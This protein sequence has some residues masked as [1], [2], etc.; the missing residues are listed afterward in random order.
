ME[1]SERVDFRLV[2]LL[3]L[4]RSFELSSR[5]RLLDLLRT[6]S[7]SEGAL[8]GEK[9]A[10]MIKGRRRNRESEKVKKKNKR[11][12]AR[13]RSSGNGVCVLLDFVSLKLSC[14][15][16]KDK[17]RFSDSERERNNT[18]PLQKNIP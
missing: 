10:M 1:D 8:K 17:D 18:M 3:R 4:R 16:G 9:M 14:A 11:I 7:L 13:N 6:V 12:L 5:R 15:T 2:L